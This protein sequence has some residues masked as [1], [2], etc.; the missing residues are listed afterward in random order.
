MTA[1]MFA[2]AT[3]ADAANTTL[4]PTAYGAKCDGVTDDRV[5]LVKWAGALQPGVVGFLPGRCLTSAPIAFPDI[6]GITIRGDGGINSS[7]IYIGAA[8]TGD[9]FIFGGVRPVNALFLDHVEFETMTTMTSGALVHI[10]NVVNS[11]M[12]GVYAG[13]NVNKAYTGL[14]LDNDGEFLIDGQWFFNGS[15][16]GV[17]MTGASGTG[18]PGDVWLKGGGEIANSNGIGLHIA[19]GVNGLNMEAGDVIGNAQNLVVDE[20][21]FATSNRELNF[22]AETF[23]DLQ[24]ST[25]RPNVEFVVSTNT[26]QDYVQFRGTWIASSATGQPC[27]QV[28]AGWQGMIDFQQGT[29]AN[30]SASG[31][32]I[33]SW[34]A[35]VVFNGTTFFN[36]GPYAINN[37]GANPNVAAKAYISKWVPSAYNGPIQPILSPLG[38]PLATWAPNQS[39]SPGQVSVDANYIYVCTAQNTVK[40]APL[41]SF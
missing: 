36:V 28:D 38:S 40:R 11:A 16:N 29:I 23:F 19:G 25:T 3:S 21:M 33:N 26:A 13:A 7:L 27:V 8:T 6:N 41:S 14:W 5:A 37:A 32:V 1:V 30:C 24:T 31:A 22:G 12:T 10:R 18:S 17:L 39:C 20:S 4:A 15:A 34:T 2:A 9:I 35:Q